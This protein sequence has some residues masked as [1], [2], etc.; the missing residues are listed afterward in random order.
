MLFLLLVKDK[1]FGLFDFFLY[2]DK[3]EDNDENGEE[4]KLFMGWMKNKDFIFNDCISFLEFIFEVILLCFIFFI[5]RWF[6]RYYFNE[7]KSMGRKC[8]IVKDI[9]VGILLRM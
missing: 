5:K 1:V 3:M 9:V 6:I 4:Y 7:R 2:C 8:L